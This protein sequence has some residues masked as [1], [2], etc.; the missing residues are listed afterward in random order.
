M[1]QYEPP[2][3]IHVHGDVPLRPE[4]S[5][6]ELQE[7]LKPL[8]KYAGARSLAA[9]AASHYD[10]EPG[11]EFDAKEHVLHLCWTVLG[12]EDFRQAL[13][14]MCMGLND[15]AETGAPI[16]VSFYDAEFD[17][18]DAGPDEEARDDFLM[19]F[20]GPTPEAIIQA[21]RDL[22]VEDV[23][24]LME[25]HFDGAE[26]GGVVAEIDKLFGQRFDALVH[27]LE[28]GKPPRGGSGSGHGGGRR[29]RHLH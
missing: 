28:L 23:V 18:E 8:W 24:H 29:P 19:L 5:F 22:L 11:I 2:F 6:D 21:Q 3:E 14:E 26:L 1:S 27:S 20:V 13:D 7:A 12:D 16:E 9:A 25:R 15:L 10:D 17:E 4:V